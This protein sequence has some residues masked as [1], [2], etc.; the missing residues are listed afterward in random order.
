MVRVEQGNDCGLDEVG[1]RV[2][3]L[4]DEPAA[5]D[6][7]RDRLMVAFGVGRATCEADTIRLFEGMTE[8]GLVR[9][10]GTAG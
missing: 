6:A 8:Q 10:D 5:V 2:W 3:E 7:V 1:G 4:T 9:V